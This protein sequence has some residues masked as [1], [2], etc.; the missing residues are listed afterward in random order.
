MLANCYQFWRQKTAA[1]HPFHVRQSCIIFLMCVTNINK[2][3]DEQSFVTP[4]I[5][6]GCRRLIVLGIAC[7]DSSISPKIYHS[8][9]PISDQIFFGQVMKS[10]HSFVTG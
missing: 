4:I 10:Q 9:E 7:L 8:I 2:K 6:V 5:D 1:Q 3:Q